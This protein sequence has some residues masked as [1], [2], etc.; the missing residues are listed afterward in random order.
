MIKP[1]ET[2][3]NGYRFRS[4]LEARWAVFFDALNITYHYESE[5]FDLGGVWYLPD[6]YLDDFEI[7]VEIKPF[8]R[9]IVNHVGD[10][11]EWEKKCRLFRDTAGKAILLCYGDPSDNLYKRFYCWDT[12]DSGGGS[13]DYDALFYEVA[14]KIVLLLSTSR[15]DREIYI[16]DDYCSYNDNI[17]TTA[18]TCKMYPRYISDCIW[19]D[20]IW[21]EF[22]PNMKNQTGKIANASLIA[23]Q[24]RFEHGETPQAKGE[25]NEISFNPFN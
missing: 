10:D 2:I 17:V 23:R 21:Q 1:I 25:I 18:G 19:N 8:D 15:P 5:G 20:A 13:S 7:Y 24:A 6:F 3:Y 9:N 22:D 11:N 14:G 16:T 12:C 4:R